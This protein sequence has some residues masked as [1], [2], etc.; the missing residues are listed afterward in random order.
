M[1]LPKELVESIAG[2]VLPYAISAAKAGLPPG[3]LFD[4]ASDAM[5]K[6]GRMVNDGLDKALK[7]GE[8]V[9]NVIQDYVD[10]AVKGGLSGFNKGCDYDEDPGGDNTEGSNNSEAVGG[11]V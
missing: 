11:V 3:K 4:A 5:E 1:K 9:E 6:V 7:D 8:I 10:A 2:F